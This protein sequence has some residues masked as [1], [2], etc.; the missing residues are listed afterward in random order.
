MLKLTAIRFA[1]EPQMLLAQIA[2]WYIAL[3][4]LLALFKD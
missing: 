1:T 3:R 2:M 4:A